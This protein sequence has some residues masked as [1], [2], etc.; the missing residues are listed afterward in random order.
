[1]NT[2]DDRIVY[3]Y[4]ATTSAMLAAAAPPSPSPHPPP[5]P[6]LLLLLLLLTLLSYSRFAIR[7]PPPLAIKALDS[8]H[9]C[10]YSNCCN[11]DREYDTNPKHYCS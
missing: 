10:K 1:M 11:S 6:L 9:H 5:P 3:G 4:M 8:R 7:P 2:T